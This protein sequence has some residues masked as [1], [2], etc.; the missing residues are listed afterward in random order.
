MTTQRWQQPC[1]RG[2]WEKREWFRGV[3]TLRHC[4]GSRIETLCIGKLQLHFGLTE[5]GFP[6][7]WR[8][9]MHLCVSCIMPERGWKRRVFTSLERIW[10]GS[11]F[12]SLPLVVLVSSLP[13]MLWCLS[14][15][16]SLLSVLCISF[17]II[18]FQ[19]TLS[20]STSLYLALSFSPSLFV[21]PAPCNT[22]TT[23]S[24][25]PWII[26]PHCHSRW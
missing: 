16:V 5:D 3:L 15:T 19:L 11:L 22:N 24:V 14:H 17:F 10:R 2:A 12:L 7:F 6:W 26:Y 8:A 21:P 13:Q 1:R 25:G 9:L 20:T 4:P 23:C 18:P